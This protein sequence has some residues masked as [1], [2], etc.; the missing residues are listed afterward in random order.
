MTAEDFS[1]QKQWFESQF[2]AVVEAS[3]Y[4]Q[5]LR[6]PLAYSCQGLG[7]RARPLLVMALAADHGVE[8]RDAVLRCAAAV[9]CIHLYSLIHD[10]LP[11]MDGGEI[12]HGRLCSHL[13][14]GEATALLTGN[15]LMTVACKL[16]ADMKCSV[17]MERI[18]QL[19]QG[20]KFDIDSSAHFSDKSELVQLFKDKTAALFCLCVEL[21]ASIQPFEHHHL[22]AFCEHI[23]IAYQIR[24][25][26]QQRCDK[27]LNKSA[28]KSSLEPNYVDVSSLAQ[29]QQDYQHHLDK[30]QNHLLQHSQ[31]QHV[32]AW[33][34][35]YV[36]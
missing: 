15:A 25:D 5:H 11:C 3:A 1:R 30:A 19:I 36:F 21:V 28:R 26:I 18:L 24:D 16:M 27:G 17:G 9:E 14:F 20:Q 6:E 32:L 31:H 8:D 4:T 12:R 7:K 35:H 23:G 34:Q 13:R 22:L 33:A 10:D 29:A 2:W